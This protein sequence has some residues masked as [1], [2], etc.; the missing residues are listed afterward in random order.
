VLIVL[1]GTAGADDERTGTLR[2]AA[3]LAAAIQPGALKILVLAVR[4]Q[5]Y[6]GVPE[7]PSSLLTFRSIAAAPTFARRLMMSRGG[8]GVKDSARSI[9]ARASDHH[10][11]STGVEAASKT[12]AG[13]HDK[14]LPASI[15]FDDDEQHSSATVGGRRRAIPL[16]FR[17]AVAATARPPKSGSSGQAVPQ[18]CCCHCCDNFVVIQLL[19]R[20]RHLHRYLILQQSY[21]PRWLKTFVMPCRFSSLLLCH[22]SL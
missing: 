6:S 10:P 13:P 8:A 14:R 22:L 16:S 20:L 21:H 9:G 1:Q 15:P 3:Q 18:C 5:W 17:L 2:V 7:A 12:V 4:P 11:H 19:K